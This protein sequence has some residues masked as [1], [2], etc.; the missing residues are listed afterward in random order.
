MS[1]NAFVFPGQGSQFVGMGREQ[2]AVRP[3]F[4]GMFDRANIALDFDL[5]QICFEGPQAALDDTHITQPA[6]FTHSLA[7]YELTMLSGEVSA[8]AYM[9][10]HSLGEFSALCAAGAFAFEDGLKLVRE[11]GRLMKQ[12]GEHTP[13]AM[14]AVIGTDMATLSAICIEA[15]AEGP[16]VPANDNC[17]GQIVIS[18]SKQGVAQAIVLAKARGIK[19]VIPLAVSIASHSPLMAAI[20]PDFVRV[21]EATRISSARIPV[22]ANTSALAITHPDDIR[23]ELAAQLTSPVR[24]TETVQV[25]HAAGIDGFVELGPKDVLCGL[26]KRTLDGANTMAVG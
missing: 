10:G 12:V 5:K 4:R 23:A 25:L 3:I 6:I 13:G 22:V 21:L 8:P 15:S 20:R 7:A 17:P 11:R 9:A 18:G 24:W 26:I 14:A 19:R 16:V 2:A 1:K